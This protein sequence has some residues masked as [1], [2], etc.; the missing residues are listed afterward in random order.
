MK[1]LVIDDALFTRK[2]YCK[3]LSK[4]FEII[5]AANG[6]EG[7]RL[8]REENPDLVICDLLMPGLN[9]FQ[10]LSEYSKNVNKA[11]VIICTSDVQEETREKCFE[12]GADE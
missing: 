8:Y 4:D 10:F 1:V 12:L 5:E 6:E 9:G 7:L 3:I 11:P 2:V